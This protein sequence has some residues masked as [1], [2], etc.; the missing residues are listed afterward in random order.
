MNRIPIW[1]V[2]G[3]CSTSFTMYGISNEDVQELD[4]IRVHI[5]TFG[6]CNSVEMRMLHLEPG[7]TLTPLKMS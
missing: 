7:Q 4:H 6:L 3:L 5:C 1:N 2:P